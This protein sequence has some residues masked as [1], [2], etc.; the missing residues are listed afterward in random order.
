MRVTSPSSPAII[1]LAFCSGRLEIQVRFTL[2]FVEGR[3][4]RR[5]CP[6]AQTSPARF[7]HAMPIVSAINR[8]KSWLCRAG[9]ALAAG[10][11]Q[12]GFPDCEA[13]RPAQIAASK[14]GA[15][16][17]STVKR[18]S[19]GVVMQK[20]LIQKDRLAFHTYGKPLKN[21]KHQKEE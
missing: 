6:V 4:C 3:L 11:L 5:F 8:S 10:R 1:A 13:L 19:H 15:A 18:P 17:A 14:K 21:V 2:R 16:N 12:P 20:V 9:P 7:F